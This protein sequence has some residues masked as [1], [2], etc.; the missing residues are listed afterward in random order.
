MKTK[1][2]IGQK[3]ALLFIAAFLVIFSTVKA[4]QQQTTSETAL[5]TKFGIK[6]GLNLTNLHS[7][8]FADNQMKAGFNAG[9]YSKIPVTPGFSIQPELLYSVKGNKSDYS[10]FVQGSGQYR[11]NLGY[12]ELPLLAVVNLAKNFS[13][14]V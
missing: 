13:I 11:F 8:D 12:I 14:H 4:Q 9:I 3:F 10:N 6:G 5:S 7:N 1:S 2:S